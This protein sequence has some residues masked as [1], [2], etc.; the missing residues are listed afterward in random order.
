VATYSEAPGKLLRHAESFSFYDEDLVD[1]RI[2]LRNLYPLVGQDLVKLRDA[3]V[4]TVA[5]HDAKLLV[6]DG[7][8]SV[9]DIQE[10]TARIRRFIHDFGAVLG[11]LNCVTMITS[12]FY[13]REGEHCRS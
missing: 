6:V 1:E 3:L 5:E 8:A 4:A 11:E 13:G 2:H 7:L 12:S 10:D 9:R